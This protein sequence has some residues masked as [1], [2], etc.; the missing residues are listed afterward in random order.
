MPDTKIEELTGEG[1][2]IGRAWTE[3]GLRVASTWVE[4]SAKTVGDVARMLGGGAE[5]IANTEDK[6]GEHTAA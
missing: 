2:R 6:E 1:A 3:Q 5:A 4:F